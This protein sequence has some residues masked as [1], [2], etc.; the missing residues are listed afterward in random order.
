MTTQEKEVRLLT[1]ENLVKTG[2]FDHADWNYRWCLGQILGRR[3]EQIVQWLPP[4]SDRLLEIGFGS[5]IFFPMLIEKCDVLYGIDVHDRSARVHRAL[6]SIGIRAN[7]VQGSVEEIPCADRSFDCIVAASSL[8]FVPNIDG[9]CSEIRRVLRPGGYFIAVTPLESP[10]LDAGLHLM[11]GE[12]ARRDFGDRRRA[13]VPALRRHF[14]EVEKK[15]LRWAGI[16]LYCALRLTGTQPNTCGAT[17]R[18]ESD[19]ARA[20]SCK[21]LAGCGARS[22]GVIPPRGSPGEKRSRTK[23]NVRYSDADHGMDGAD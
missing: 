19:P 15:T 16:P 20:Q 4:H 17:F 11:T 7:L 1:P 3:Y 5:G 21:I 6:S 10:L 12:S 23:R 22:G 13:V 2:P 14:V 8:E 18:P 9:A